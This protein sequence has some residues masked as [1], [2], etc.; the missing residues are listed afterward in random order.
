M[1]HEW[2]FKGERRWLLAI[3]VLAIIGAACATRT[4]N[5]AWLFPALLLT[6][7]RWFMF[8]RDAIKKDKEDG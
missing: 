1:M 6:A 3:A 4:G 2:T 5:G 8:W 7:Y